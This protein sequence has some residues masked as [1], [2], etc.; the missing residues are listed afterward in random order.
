MKEVVTDG[1]RFLCESELEAWR[2]QTLLTKEPG[3]IAWL[4]AQLKPGEV[5]CDVGANIGC[6][7]LYAARIV[8]P[9]GKVFA[10]EPHLVNA[11]SLM[12]NIQANGYAD[13]ASVLTCAL[14]GPRFSLRYPGSYGAVLPF[15]YRALDA[16][17]S[18]SQLEHCTGEDGRDFAPAMVELKMAITLGELIP[19]GVIDKPHLVKIDVDGN[20]ADILRGL[21]THDSGH[22]WPRSLQVEMHPPDRTRIQALLTDAGYQQTGQHFTQHGQQAIDKGRDPASITDNA[23]FEVRV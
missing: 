5:F 15:N 1:L 20:E 6:Y 4:K 18:G 13:R 7:T 14:R 3:T 9:T 2:A 22:L 23:V 12:R 21:L 10:F 11:V 17:S 8:G 19:M 16:G